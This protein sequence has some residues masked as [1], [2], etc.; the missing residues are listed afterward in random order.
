[1]FAKDCNQNSKVEK[2]ARMKYEPASTHAMR[3]RSLLSLLT[4]SVMLL[5]MITNHFKD[6]AQRAVYARTLTRSDHLIVESFE[7][8]KFADGFDI[9]FLVFDSLLVLFTVGTYA[10]Q[11]VLQPCIVL[12][13]S[14][15]Y[16]KSLSLC[17]GFES[18]VWNSLEPTAELFVLC[19]VLCRQ[20]YVLTLLCPLI[21]LIHDH[22]VFSELR[23]YITSISVAKTEWKQH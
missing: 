13:F 14:G 5:N 18:T 19:T 8:V 21:V 15:W 20:G 4:C 7:V 12:A 17:E 3:T 2:T 23:S 1:M 9:F 22:V 10:N 6:I 16:G 11:E